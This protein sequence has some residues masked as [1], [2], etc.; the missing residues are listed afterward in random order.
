MSLRLAE[1]R[2]LIQSVGL[3]SDQAGL[4]KR[5]SLEAFLFEFFRLA[6]HS[7]ADG[8]SGHDVRA[9]GN[10]NGPP[11]GKLIAFS[12]ASLPDNSTRHP[13]KRTFHMWKSSGTC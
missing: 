9:P 1:N 7:A 13:G 11:R 4:A 10:K 2:G 12:S 8:P 5:F 3:V 6:L